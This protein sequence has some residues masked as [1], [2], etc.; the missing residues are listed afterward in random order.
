MPRS[1]VSGLTN[2]LVHLG[3]LDRD[4]S[5]VYRV[6]SQVLSVAYP[7]LARFKIRQAARPFM[8]D[9]A[10]R[11]G[12]NVSMAMSNGLH[13]IMLDV[14]RSDDTVVSDYISDI[15]FSVPLYSTAV[16]RAIL[17]LLTSGERSALHTRTLETA[18]HLAGETSGAD[19]GPDDYRTE[20]RA[21]GKE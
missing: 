14:T 8:R 16:G 17:S 18:P 2:T 20:K 21:R 1:S 9:F 19:R 11:A 12:G 6:G 15:G 13:A 3:Y 10:V 5:G 4:E 7:L